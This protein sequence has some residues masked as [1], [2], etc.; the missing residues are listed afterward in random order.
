M[1]ACARDKA[2]SLTFELEGLVSFVF[3]ESISD[4]GGWHPL[5]GGVTATVNQGL[6]D[7]GSPK[8]RMSAGRQVLLHILGCSRV[9]C[10]RFSAGVANMLNN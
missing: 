6:P 10:A 2:T 8:R 7:S 3:Y 1:W 4:S 5:A 9:T